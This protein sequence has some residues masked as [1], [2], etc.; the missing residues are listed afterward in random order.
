MNTQSL[1]HW[2]NP[3]AKA[4]FIMIPLTIYKPTLQ[5]RTDQTLFRPGRHLATV[6][7]PEHTDTITNV[8]E[9][10]RRLFTCTHFAINQVRSRNRAIFGSSSHL[11]DLDCV[12]KSLWCV[13]SCLR[14]CRPRTS[15]R[16]SSGRCFPASRVRSARVKAPSKVIHSVFFQPSPFE[17]IA[18]RSVLLWIRGTPARSIVFVPIWGSCWYRKFGLFTFLFLGPSK[19]LRNSRRTLLWQFFR[20]I[21]IQCVFLWIWKFF[22][23]K[24]AC[25]RVERRRRKKNAVLYC[26]ENSCVLG[27]TVAEFVYAGEYRLKKKIMSFA[28]KW[29]KIVKRCMFQ[30]QK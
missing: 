25:C 1:F 6:S 22:R 13:C 30:A 24:V 8:G 2:V 20:T 9:L 14:T 18:I 3:R 19:T 29:K 7:H 21:F 17:V 26:V 16:V 27:W 15:A 11:V 5:F 28:V 10:S 23:E 12:G 4:F